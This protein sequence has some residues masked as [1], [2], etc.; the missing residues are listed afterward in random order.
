MY[1]K[2]KKAISMRFP[3]IR[4]IFVIFVLEAWA[5]WA[6]YF[7]TSSIKITKVGVVVPKFDSKILIV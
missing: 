7:F 6:F 1:I 4:V 5:L 2:T 3:L